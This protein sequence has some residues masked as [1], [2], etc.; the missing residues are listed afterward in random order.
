MAAVLAFASAGR[1]RQNASAPPIDYPYRAAFISTLTGHRQLVIFP[2]RGSAFK[3]SIPSLSATE[4]SP[5]G[6]SLYGPCTPYRDQEKPGDLVKIVV[7]KFDLDSG[8]TTPLPGIADDHIPHRGNDVLASARRQTLGLTLPAG[9]PI[10]ISLPADGHPW[11]HLSLSPDGER[12]V[13][14][15]N[16]RVELIDLT[17]GT[18]QP[19][20]DKYFIAAWSP[21]GK[22][23]AT[24][25]KGENG[26]TLLLDA[27]SLQLRRILGNSELDWSPDSRFLLGMKRHN[28]C[29]AYSGTLE[30]ID[31][32]TGDR[33]TIESSRCQ[34]NQAMTGW[35]RSDISVK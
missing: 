19:L 5:D 32:V 20:D 9:K 31:I 4:F 24:V 34:V 2:F 33:T 29:G 1:S 35:V 23:L 22:W 8:I 28:G 14:T 17:H 27:A 6:R 21:D 26:R 12:A 13:A 18:A 11:Q 3:I 25:E 7:C 30:A 16:S 15:H 10:G